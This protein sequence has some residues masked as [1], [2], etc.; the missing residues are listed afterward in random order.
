MLTSVFALY[1][2]AYVIKTMYFDKAE[3]PYKFGLHSPVVTVIIIAL[4]GVFLF[5]LMPEPVI[6][7]AS[8]IPMAW[9]FTGH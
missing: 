8:Q 5:G 1:Y 3:S 6:R 9:G 4:V 2:Y 7:F